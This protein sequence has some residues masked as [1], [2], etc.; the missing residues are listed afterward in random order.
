MKNSFDH[1][2]LKVLP[3]A[4]AKLNGRDVAGILIVQV[5]AIQDRT[6]VQPGEVFYLSGCDILFLVNTMLVGVEK[7]IQLVFDSVQYFFTHYY[8]V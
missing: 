6:M 8:G 7:E 3:S 4:S 5:G 1:L 2:P